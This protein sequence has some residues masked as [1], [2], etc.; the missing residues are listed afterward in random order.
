VRQPQTETDA[1]L[2]DH[3][4][5]DKNPRNNAALFESKYGRVDHAREQLSDT[6]ALQFLPY[7]LGDQHHLSSFRHQ[8]WHVTD[9]N[10]LRS[11]TITI[12]LGM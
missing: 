5:L 9:R 1:M 6:T 2:E 4:M 11:E 7:T 3:V 8:P 10:S 12:P